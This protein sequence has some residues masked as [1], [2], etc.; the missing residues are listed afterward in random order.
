M[1]PSS[2][3]RKTYVAETNFAARKR[4]MILPE[5]TTF[6]SERRVFQFS[7]HHAFKYEA[8]SRQQTAN[9]KDYLRIC[10]LFL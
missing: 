8:Y 2:T 7:H 4:K 1:F 5:V 10:V 9:G 6:A 3:E